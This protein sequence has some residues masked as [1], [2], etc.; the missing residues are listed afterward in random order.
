MACCGCSVPFWSMRS[1]LSLRSGMRL[2]AVATAKRNS[3][4]RAMPPLYAVARTCHFAAF[5]SPFPP[6]HTA[7]CPLCPTAPG[8]CVP[9]TPPPTF[10]TRAASATF[11]LMQRPNKRRSAHFSILGTP[12]TFRD[13]SSFDDAYIKK[14]LREL[15]TCII[16]LRA[17]PQIFRSLSQHLSVFLLIKS[18]ENVILILKRS[19]AVCA[20]PCQS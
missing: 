8:R 18:G 7:P 19:G 5:L 14:P 20:A 16:S 1:S 10:R 13:P 6:L 3:K 2:W 17:N 11:S 9:Y 12:C 15:L 4:A